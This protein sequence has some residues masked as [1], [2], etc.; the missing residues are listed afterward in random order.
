MRCYSSLYFVALA[1]LSTTP[2]RAQSIDTP[3]LFGAISNFQISS[4]YVDVSTGMNGT[5]QALTVYGSVNI[6]LFQ[7]LPMRGWRLKISGHYSQYR[8]EDRISTICQQNSSASTQPPNADIS[9]ACNN[10]ADA[11]FVSS[12]SFN[13]FLNYYGLH[14]EG[15]NLV[16][17]KD[18]QVNRY[19]LSVKPGYAWSLGALTL[20]TF[21]GLAYESENLTALDN[22]Y[23][24][25]DSV[26]GAEGT[27]EAW[28]QLDD[29][30]WFSANG[31]Y[32]TGS[33]S[34][35]A[36][37]KYGYRQ[38]EWLGLGPELAV[39]G[40]KAEGAGGRAGAFIRIYDDTIETTLSGGYSSNYKDDPSLYGSANLYMRF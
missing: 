32:F 26:I 28:L 40:D 29:K 35:S 6:G 25:T 11:D 1:A 33:Q 27:V 12:Q 18:Y 2:T 34:Y 23:R 37:L 13:N 4:K 14:L 21:L 38:S 17:Y 31:A 10:L 7:P 8:Y 24:S 16:Q 39:Y 22:S 3:A 36:D 19:H 5:A 20:K 9:T 30:N 15:Q